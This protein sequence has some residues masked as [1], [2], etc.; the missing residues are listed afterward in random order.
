MLAADGSPNKLDMTVSPLL[1]TF[2][3]V[4]HELEEIDHLGDFRG[5]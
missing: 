2:V 5:V 4:E 3:Y 1:K